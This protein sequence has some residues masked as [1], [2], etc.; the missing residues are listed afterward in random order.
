MLAD[1]YITRQFCTIIKFNSRVRPGGSA[2]D[3]SAKPV[4]E[5]FRTL[6]TYTVNSIGTPFAVYDTVMVIF[7]IFAGF[8]YRKE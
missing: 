2:V 3:K 5:R 8:K 7:G 4:N 6:R 1:L